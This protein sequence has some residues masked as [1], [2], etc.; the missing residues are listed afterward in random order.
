MARHVE[1]TRDH[2]RSLEIARDRSRSL[3]IARD[4]S[5]SLCPDRGRTARL[6]RVWG[7]CTGEHHY[8]WV[9]VPEPCACAPVRVCDRRCCPLRG[10]S[11]GTE[12]VPSPPQ[13]STI[14]STSRRAPSG[15]SAGACSPPPH[16]HTHSRSRRAELREARPTRLRRVVRLSVSTRIFP[17]VPA[18]KRRARAPPS[19]P[20]TPD[21]LPHPGGR[22][23]ASAHSP[24]QPRAARCCVC[25]LPSAGI[26]RPPRNHWVVALRTLNR[27]QGGVR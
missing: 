13:V 9:V 21:T 15:P 18:G 23:P 10:A 16:T 3:E 2:P 19:P 22:T 6:W 24:H 5:R 25:Q 26:R 8:T 11:R 1:I 4:R 7:A 14:L 20:F 12:A 27:A 17:R